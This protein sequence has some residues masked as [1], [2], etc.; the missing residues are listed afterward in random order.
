MVESTSDYSVRT[1]LQASKPN[2]TQTAE[3][4]YVRSSKDVSDNWIPSSVSLKASLRLLKRVVK[5]KKNVSSYESIKPQN[6]VSHIYD[7]TFWKQKKL[8]WIRMKKM[9]PI[10]IQIMQLHKY[11]FHIFRWRNFLLETFRRTESSF[12]LVWLR[13][14]VG[15]LGEKLTLFYLKS[16]KVDATM[17]LQCSLDETFLQR[18][19]LGKFC[20]SRLIKSLRWISTSPF[21]GKLSSNA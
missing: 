20:K 12:F 18:Q 2:E 14:S 11:F 16:W 8:K 19:N 10:H 4:M 3:A 15:K 6:S 1:H 21:Y 17:K 9:F 13:Y 7:C 5:G